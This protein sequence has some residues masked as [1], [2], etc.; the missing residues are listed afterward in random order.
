MPYPRVHVSVT[1]VDTKSGAKPSVFIEAQTYDLSELIG[2]IHTNEFLKLKTKLHEVVEDNDHQLLFHKDSLHRYRFDE[3]VLQSGA[4]YG[5]AVRRKGVEG[6]V[7]KKVT[8]S[9]LVPILSPVDFKK[10]VEDVAESIFQR[11][12]RH[13]RL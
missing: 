5:M 11:R 4:L 10:Y 8:V 3:S 6:E 13:N 1:F 2:D 12:G 7:R 9:K